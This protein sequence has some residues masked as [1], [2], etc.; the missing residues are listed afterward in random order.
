MFE[1][2][3]KAFA[4]ALTAVLGLV[5]QFIPALAVVGPETIAMVA[6]ALSVA[7]C[8]FIENRDHGQNVIKVA[9]TATEIIA[10]SYIAQAQEDGG[11]PDADALD[12]R[13]VEAF[14]ALSD[15]KAVARGVAVSVGQRAVADLL[16]AK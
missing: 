1:K 5:A 14:G 6:A 16:G 10:A 2:Y 8:Y 11:T 9:E 13:V 7:A 4:V 3:R 15:P 12:R